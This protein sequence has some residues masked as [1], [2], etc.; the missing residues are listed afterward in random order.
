M[1]DPRGLGRP[2][3]A[4]EPDRSQPAGCGRWRG[5]RMGPG[6]SAPAARTAHGAGVG[7]R[8]V[9]APRAMSCP[10]TPGGVGGGVVAGWDPAGQP[11]G[12]RRHG[13]GV[14]PRGQWCTAGDA[15]DRSHRRGVARWRGRRMGPGWPVAGADG[16]VRVWDRDQVWRRASVA[17]APGLTQSVKLN[18]SHRRGAGGGVV[19]GW[20][21]AG[22]RRRRSATVRVWE[23]GRRRLPRL[24][25]LTGHTGGVRGGG[26]VAGWDPAGQRPAT[27]ARCG[28]G[29]AAQWGAPLVILPGHTGWGCGRWRGHQI[30]PVSPPRAPGCDQ[31]RGPR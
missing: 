30:A 18:W 2:D 24:V 22:Q 19:A 28:C 16:T 17:A 6:W 20:D 5:R 21:P 25:S 4:A 15:P 9:G 23:R 1:A 29:I 26:V 14:E 10:V 12:R 7:P 27:T 8:P 31:H 13:A 11:P 3:L